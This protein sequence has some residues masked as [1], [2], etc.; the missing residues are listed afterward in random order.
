MRYC[1][2][3]FALYGSIF[4]GLVHLILL[5]PISL[6]LQV[7]ERNVLPGIL[8]LSGSTMLLAVLMGAIGGPHSH[9]Q[10]KT[11]EVKGCG[12]SLLFWKNFAGKQKL[13]SGT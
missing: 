11:H 5:V 6:S 1:S 3:L 7:G 8:S 12:A 13:R 2:V 4:L 9:F 10:A